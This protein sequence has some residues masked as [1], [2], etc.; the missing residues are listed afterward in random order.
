MSTLLLP[1]GALSALFKQWRCFAIIFVAVIVAG[2]SYLLFATQ[3]YE[4]VAELVVTFGDRSVPE[5]DRLPATELTP[6]DRHEIVLAHAALLGS[7][8][9]AQATIEA[10]GIDRVYPD[11]VKN[12]PSRGTPMD[13]AIRQFL[14]NQSVD[15]GIQDDIITLSLRHPDKELVPQLVRKLIELYVDRQ[16]KVYNNPHQNFMAAE[17]QRANIRLA[18]A[19]A[20]LE[21]FK[22]RWH[23]TDYDKEVEDLL[24]QRGDVDTNLRTAEANLAQAQRRQE[25]LEQLIRQ[26]PEKLPESASS[27]KYRSLDDA[28]TR[29]ADLRTKNSQM[30]AT[31]IPDGPAMAALK[32]GIASAEADVAARTRELNNRSNTVPNVVYQTMQTDYLRTNADAEG[33]LQPVRVLTDQ[34]D[35]ID[36]RLGDLQSNRG[37]FNDLLRE[38][39]IAEEAYHSLSVQYADARVK[40]NLNDQRISPAVVISEPTEPYKTVR[41]RKLITVLACVVG[42]LIL[43]TGGALLRES[44]DDRFTTAEQVAFLL[45]LPVL[46]SLEHQPHRVPLALLALGEPE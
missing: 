12:P 6:S 31:Y 21:Q 28:Q 4:S 29:L 26:V 10:F 35:A 45:D 16:T 14:L 32:A 44:L 13:E 7:H 9:L 3:K 25:Q 20:A 18:T 15:V 46:A 22:G 34:L 41:P 27:E 19:Q 43:A 39:Q 36:H 1:Y 11:I 33:Y 23:L 2:G 42:G 38:Q 5:V 40:S 37:S 30:L 17:V 8:D 24:K